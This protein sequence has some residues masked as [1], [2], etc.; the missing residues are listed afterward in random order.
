MDIF[1]IAAIATIIGTIILLWDKIKPL[2]FRATGFQIFSSSKNELKQLK[3]SPVL[4]KNT[5]SIGTHKGKPAIWL[6]SHFIVSNLSE[7]FNNAV[8]SVKTKKHKTHGY[9]MTKFN[10]YGAWGGT[11]QISPN[12]SCDLW[13]TFFLNNKTV[14]EG[15]SINLDLVFFDK[16]YNTYKIKDILFEYI[17]RKDFTSTNEI[18]QQSSNTD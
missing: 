11:E 17:Q 13:A 9:I 12:S 6:D 1:I 3:I 7:T 15:K 18:K 16:Y 8:T 14:K 4:Q 2:L 5:W 10:K